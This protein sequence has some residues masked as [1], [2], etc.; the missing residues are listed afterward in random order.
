MDTHNYIMERTQKLTSALY[1]VTDLLPNN[2][3]LKWI[4]RNR[5]VNLYDNLVSFEF[6]KDKD[7]VL[8]EIFNN[9]SQLIYLLELSFLG[10]S[11]GS[12]NYNILKREYESLRS[13]IEGKK[14]EIVP[15]QKLLSDISI[16]HN[17]GHCIGPL[18]PKVKPLENLG[19]KGLTL[20]RK[21]KIL[22]FL[23]NGGYKTISEISSI[24][25]INEISEKTIQRDLSE[26]VNIGKLSADGERRWRRYKLT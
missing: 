20:D 13:F 9:L 14:G 23:K 11:I 26:L 24:F 19:N 10:A 1:R 25:N 16:G 7:G 18:S 15:E 17:I 6:S 8:N 2:E 21:Q 22:D 4:L 12:L 3:P 5:A